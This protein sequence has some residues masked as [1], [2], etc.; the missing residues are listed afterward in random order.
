MKTARNWAGI[1]VGAGILSYGIAA[2][3]A[4]AEP[5]K[6]APAAAWPVSVSSQYK[7][8]FNG[9]EVGGFSFK[10][11]FNGKTYSA[12][13][14][15]NVSALF[16][17]FKWKGTNTAQGA[18]GEAGPKP[19]SYQMNFRTKSKAGIVKLGFDKSGV[20]SVSIEPKKDPNPESVPVKPEHLKSVLDPITTVI[21][22]T[23][24]ANGNPCNQ[25]LS[26]FDGKVRFN[27]TLT[28]KGQEKLDEKQPSG[29]P[30]SL[31][32]CKVKYEPVSGHKPKDFENPWVDYD[33][34]EM[35]L[36]PVP[37]AGIFVPYRIS[38]PT[39]IG[40]AVMIAGRIDIT[41]ANNSVIALTQ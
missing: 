7:L 37:S 21:S 39:T 31:Y 25:R 1:A 19:A 41:S 22:M 9:F 24:P 27:L 2:G 35:A 14:S 29:Q 17:A 23:R 38:V 10:S 8:F 33:S 5:A 30:S 15:A 28:Y 40:A 6:V 36:R 20:K 26:V 32:V 12:T 18:I 4:A 13:S 34:I 16:G 11:S 3:A